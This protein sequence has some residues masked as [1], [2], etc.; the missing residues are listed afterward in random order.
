V[1]RR[2]L[3]PQP[4][5]VIRAGQPPA[6]SRNRHSP[7]IRLRKESSEYSSS[8]QRSRTPVWPQKPL[9]S[10]ISQYPSASLRGPACRSVGPPVSTSTLAGSSAAFATPERRCSIKSAG[11]LF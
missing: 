6:H 8:T 11:S 4:A 1:K 7:Y 3:K 9:R 2:D 10:A 5:T